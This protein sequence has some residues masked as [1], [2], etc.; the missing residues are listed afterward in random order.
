M[1]INKVERVIL[2]QSKL[3]IEGNHLLDFNSGLSTLKVQQC[4]PGRWG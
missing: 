4:V 2:V 1:E 3:M